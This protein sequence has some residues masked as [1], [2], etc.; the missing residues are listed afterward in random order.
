MQDAPGGIDIGNPANCDARCNLGLHGLRLEEF[1][2][3]Q[4]FDGGPN[5]CLR[6]PRHRDLARIG[7]LRLRLLLQLYA[8]TEFAGVDWHQLNAGSRSGYSRETA[9]RFK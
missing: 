9:A 1:A 8:V 7:I 4:R 2:H 6:L 5:R 3:A